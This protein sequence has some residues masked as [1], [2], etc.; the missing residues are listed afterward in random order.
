MKEFTWLGREIIFE[1]HVAVYILIVFAILSKK[2]INNTFKIN[3][4]IKLIIILYLSYYTQ[5]NTNQYNNNL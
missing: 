2:I 3:K 4:V 5:T 1:V